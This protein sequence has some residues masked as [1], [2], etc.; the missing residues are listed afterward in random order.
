MQEMKVIALV[1]E[2]QDEARAL[3]RAGGRIGFVPTMGYLHGGHLSLVRLAREQ[4]DFVIVSIFVNPTQFAPG[5]DL[6]SYPRD[7]DRDEELC[8]SEGVDLLFYP[9]AEDMYHPDSSVHV[10]ED[11]LSRGLCGRTRPSHFRGVC[12]VVAK[13]LN[14]IQPDFAVFGEKDYQQLAILRRM[15]RDLNFAVEVVAGPIVREA[16]GLAISSRNKHLGPEERRQ[17]ICLRRALDLAEHLHAGGE[18]DAERIRE[19]M[20]SHIAS[21]PSARIDYIE[22]VDADTLQPL[23][24][25]TGRTLVALAV[26]IGNTRLIDNTVIA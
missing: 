12:T 13:L 9:S 21:T 2:M 16:D 26:F 19:R 10:A 25:I 8:R 1:D 3:R 5:E 23:D 18:R 4:A 17:A 14:I 11:S 7:F 24:R 22:V 15:V 20:R 6:D